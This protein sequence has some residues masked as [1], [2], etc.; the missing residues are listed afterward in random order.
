MTATNAAVQ[1]EE[2]QMSTE[3]STQKKNQKH[4]PKNIVIYI[5]RVN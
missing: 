5:L 4:T 1:T 3:K 2:L